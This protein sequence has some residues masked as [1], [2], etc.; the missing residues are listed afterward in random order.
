MKAGFFFILL[1]IFSLDIYGQDKL[2]GGRRY[3]YC[4]VYLDDMCFGTAAGDT[5]TMIN[6]G[7][8]VIYRAELSG[9]QK[10]D[11]YAG[12]NP[13]ADLVYENDAKNCPEKNSDVCSYKVTKEGADIL[14]R[15][16]PEAHYI[17]IHVNGHVDMAAYEFVRNFRPCDATSNGIQCKNGSIFGGL[18]LMKI[19]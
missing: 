9:G 10:V 2:P 6:A 8:Y 19:K 14:Y 4:N 3:V 7:D 5:V 1:A 18:P 11:I 17:H 15:K 13:S 16:S 12:Y